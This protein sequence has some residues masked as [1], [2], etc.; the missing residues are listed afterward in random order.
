MNNVR[1]AKW[2]VFVFEAVSAY[3]A[4]LYSTY[5]YFCLAG[6]FGFS[7]KQNLLVAAANGVFA[8]LGA[9]GGSRLSDKIGG[10]NLLKLAIVWVLITLVVADRFEHSVG[11]QIL[12]F[13]GWCL[14]ISGTWPILQSLIDG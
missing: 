12:C 1:L 3:A 7:N 5:F 9:W 6:T 4:T 13:L 8:T 11:I 14:G 10:P 2:P